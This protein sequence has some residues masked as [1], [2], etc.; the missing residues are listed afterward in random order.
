MIETP[1][2]ILREWLESDA[3][4]LYKYASDPD[5]GTP[6]GWPPHTSVE[7]SLFVIR[8]VFSAPNTF[9]VVLKETNEVIGC[10]GIVPEGARPTDFIGKYELEIGYWLGKPLWGRGII[11]EAVQALCDYTQKHLGVK[12]LWIAF[13]DDNHKSMRVAEKC[14]FVY[15]HTLDCESHR[16]LYYAKDC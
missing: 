12:R 6:A 4:D 11:P 7:M 13:N 14:G 8:E 9:A 10:C 1:R 2:L 16:E 5:V 15:R 3:D